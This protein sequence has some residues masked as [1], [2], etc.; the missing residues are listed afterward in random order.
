MVAILFDDN[1]GVGMRQK[2]A[3]DAR[4]GQ[5]RRDSRLH[6][7][8]ARREQDRVPVIAQVGVPLMY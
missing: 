5:D 3:G 7:K 6:M 1:G 4:L 2:T 8:L